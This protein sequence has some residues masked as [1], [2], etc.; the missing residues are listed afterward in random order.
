MNKKAFTLAEVLITLGIIGVVAAMTIPT[1]LIN[2]NEKVW[3]NADEVFVNRFN[4]AM[5]LMNVDQNIAG[6]ASTKDFVNAFSKYM[7]I[8]NICDKDNLENCFG[9]TFEF[10]GT[11][12]STNDINSSARFGLEDWET[13]IVGLQFYSGVD[14]LLAYNKNCVSADKYS[15]STSEATKCTALLYDVNGISKPN[16]VNRDIKKYN[17]T[18]IN[19]VIAPPLPDELAS[20]FA[21]GTFSWDDD[22]YK[23]FSGVSGSG[24]SSY[25]NCSWDNDS[26]TSFDCNDKW[27]CDKVDDGYWSCG[28]DG[29]HVGGGG[30]IG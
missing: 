26:Y 16:I 29:Q 15:N 11:E 19:N 18:S 2:I 24:W 9:S 14:A 23:T 27:T 30:Q 3:E 4:E 22:S 10:E 25:Q 6:Y 1:L 7:K 12:F 21:A 28:H 8:A 20:F 17:V 13:E 5:R